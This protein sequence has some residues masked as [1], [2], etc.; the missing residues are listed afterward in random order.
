LSN[1]VSRN[2]GAAAAGQWAGGG[3]R[4]QAR[5][6][7]VIQRANNAGIQMIVLRFISRRI[8]QSSE[9]H[10]AFV[11]YVGVKVRRLGFT[12]FSFPFLSNSAKKSR[13]RASQ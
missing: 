12:S 9:L 5:D 13:D 11:Q 2:F 6:P 7:V 10:R 8:Q 3:A 1:F 4:L